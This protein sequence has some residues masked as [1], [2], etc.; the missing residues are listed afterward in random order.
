VRLTPRAEPEA[1]GSRVEA[2]SLSDASRATSYP[3]PADDV[4]ARRFDDVVVLINLKT[5]RMFE[6]NS[7][8]ARLWDL[9]AEGATA[10]EI[11][12][13]MRR[14]FDVADGDLTAAIDSLVDRLTAEGL[15]ENGSA[16]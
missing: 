11:H 2:E 4:V 15:I 13:V 7:T 6:L 16:A 10:A 8:G 5:D 3:K 1:R 14:E 12:D 9:I